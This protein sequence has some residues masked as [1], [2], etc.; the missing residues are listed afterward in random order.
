MSQ[1]LLPFRDLKAR[2]IVSNW[3]TLLRWIENE[4]FPAGIKLGPN[5]RAWPEDQIEAWVASRQKAGAA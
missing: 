4:G 5:S 3:P 1:R 2:G